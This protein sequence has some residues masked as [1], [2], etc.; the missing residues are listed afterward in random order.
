MKN[1]ILF[2]ADLHL[3]HEAI[4]GYS[5]RPYDNTGRMNASLIGRFNKIVG[6][7]DDVYIIGDLTL[8]S[9]ENRAMIS[10]WVRKMNGNKR[11][12]LG[13]HDKLNPFDYVEMGFLSVHT[14]FQ[15]NHNGRHWVMVHDPSAYEA[16]DDGAVLLHGHIHRLYKTLL[17]EKRI[18]NVGVDVWDYYPVD[19]ETLEQ[20]L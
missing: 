4:I 3:D 1:K 6:V 14:A 13:N 2:T 8:R 16:I 12:I 15:I 7:N 11:L 5:H 9:S 18:I 19:I 20:L 10:R 17:P